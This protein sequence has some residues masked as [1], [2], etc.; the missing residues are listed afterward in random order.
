M[1]EPL[2][3]YLIVYFGGGFSLILLVF[4]FPEKVEI[5][6]SYF[7]RL[8]R[9]ISERAEKN[10]I[11]SDIQGRVNDFS[12]SLKREIK[13][14]EPIAIKLEWV[15]KNEAKISFIK[16]NQIIIRLRKSEDQNRNFVLAALAF[17]SQS[18]LAK[19]KTYISKT[20][21]ESI[22]L[23]VAKKLF[24]KEKPQVMDCFLTDYLHQMTGNTKISEYFDK[25]S[26]IDKVGLFFPLLM[27]ELTFLGNKI[28]GNKREDII[29]KEVEDLVNFLVSY[30][31][32]ELGDETNTT[33]NRQY[34]RF[35]IMIIANSSRVKEGNKEPYVGYLKHLIRIGI[36]NIYLVGPLKEENLNFSKDLCFRA[37]VS[38]NLICFFEKQYTT[39]IKID[40]IRKKVIGF[41]IMLRSKDA[42]YHYDSEDQKMHQ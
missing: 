4:L 30:S 13:N 18:V 26:I 15:E 9:H 11:A 2:L 42:K 24:E 8:I 19:A 23:Y 31:E 17:I 25:F 3:R 32:R 10:Y 28:F 20:Q 39:Y 5:W 16:D 1:L 35:G 21:K 36:E 38:L 14:Y 29:I 33:F 27:Q 7:W 37:E 34:C 41:L 22:D 12:K 6:A 40:G